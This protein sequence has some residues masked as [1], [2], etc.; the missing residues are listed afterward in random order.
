MANP[1][2]QETQEQQKLAEQVNPE[3]AAAA[4][5]AGETTAENVAN[6][7]AAQGEMPLR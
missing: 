3:Q 2:I 4:K 7:T 5:A 1:D 6:V